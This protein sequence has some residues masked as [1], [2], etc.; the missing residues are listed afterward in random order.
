MAAA[1]ARLYPE[2]WRCTDSDISVK[3][4]KISITQAVVKISLPTLPQ[5]KFLLVYLN[6]KLQLQYMYMMD[7]TNMRKINNKSQKKLWISL[8]K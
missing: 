1:P 8:A 3:T 4:M 7:C 6:Q 2:A 5:A